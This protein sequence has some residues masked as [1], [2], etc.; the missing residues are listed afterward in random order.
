MKILSPRVLRALERFNAT[1]PWDHNAHYHRW[2]LRQL[3]RRFPRALDIGSGSGD[4]ARLLAGRAADVSGIDADPVITARARQLTPATLPVTFTVADAAADVPDGSYDV[5]TC[6][7]TLHH[8]PFAQ[9]LTR[10]RSRLAPG[11]TLVIVGLAR[12]DTPVDHLLGL[13]AIPAN[14]ATGWLKNKG[15]PSPRPVSM[16]APTRSADMTF[17]EIVRET[18]E[19]LPGARLRRRLFW[20]YTLVWRRP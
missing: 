8:L 13:V 7:A 3:P 6:V 20:R 1:Y 19:I 16:T 5:I 15:R 11:G 9:A 12:A 4:L 17:A 18:E 14:A 10:F 2:I